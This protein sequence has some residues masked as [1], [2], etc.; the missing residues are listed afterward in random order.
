MT[1]VLGLG[2]GALTTAS[3]L[4]QVVRALRTG[5]TADLSW[6]WLIMLAVG[7][8]GWLMYGLLTANLSITVTNSVT[9]ILSGVLVAIK[10][11]HDLTPRPIG[12][13]VR[14]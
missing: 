4:P 14:R 2:S 11:R 5:R 8:V 13:A 12:R 9:I 10:A 3:F 6:L 7:F 1:T